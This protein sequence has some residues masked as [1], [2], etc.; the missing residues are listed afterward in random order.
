MYSELLFPNSHQIGMSLP[1]PHLALHIS[2]ARAVKYNGA[3]KPQKLLGDCHLEG[4]SW[5]R[6]VHTH[7]RH[8][9]CFERQFVHPA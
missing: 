2:F 9:H 4:A 1:S 6:Y 3:L 8:K 7:Y 5:L